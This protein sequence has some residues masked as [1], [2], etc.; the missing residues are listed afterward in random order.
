MVIVMAGTVLL[1]CK[2]CAGKVRFVPMAAGEP[3]E[4]DVDFLHDSAAGTSLEQTYFV[5]SPVS[6]CPALGNG[7]M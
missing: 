2:R 4:A 3:I 5:C 7:W 1:K 6:S